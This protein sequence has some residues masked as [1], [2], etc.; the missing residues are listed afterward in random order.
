[1]PLTTGR[2]PA[3]TLGTGDR[4]L[5]AGPDRKPFEVTVSRIHRDRFTDAITIYLEGRTVRAGSYR[6]DALAYVTHRAPRKTAAEAFGI[7][8]QPATTLAIGD[9]YIAHFVRDKRHSREVTVSYV[10]DCVDGSFNVH[11]QGADPIRTSHFTSASLVH[12]LHRAPR[13]DHGGHWEDCM[14]C[15]EIEWPTEVQTAFMA[16]ADARSAP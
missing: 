9:R 4:Y 2:Q 13:C 11:H 5:I 16:A 6:P 10:W 3:H 8:R 12:V 1:M 7:G 14:F 15:G